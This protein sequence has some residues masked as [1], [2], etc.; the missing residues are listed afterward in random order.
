MG[1]GE[2]V[3]VGAVGFSTEAVDDAV[4]GGALQSRAGEGRRFAE[5]RSLAPRSLFAQNVG[6]EPLFL[7]AIEEHTV[8]ATLEEET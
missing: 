2:A 6:P 5:R 4:C 1:S 3:A 8:V 7:E